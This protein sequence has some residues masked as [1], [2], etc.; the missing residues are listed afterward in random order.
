MKP[1]TILAS[2]AAFP[3]ER[4]FSMIELLVVLTVL[5][6][7][8]GAIVF[9]F[10]GNK[11]AYAADDEAIKILS[12]CR[13]AYQRALSQRQAQKLT[14]DRQNKLVKLT[15]MGTL[16]GGDEMLI[17]RGVLNADVSLDQPRVGASLLPP[18]PAPYNYAPAAFDS[19][20]TIDL[21]FLADG[22][23]TNSTGFNNS[24]FAPVSLTIFFSPSTGTA[25][26]SEQVAAANAGNLMRAITI[27]GPTGSAKFW[28]FDKDKFIWEIN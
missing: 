10:R 27:Y 13:E 14:I 19:A 22:S 26:T 1:K 18:P 12:F 3:R 5:T 17:N 16:P 7:M 28:R 9:A 24:T 6:I 8:T 2:S 15:D 23:V 20:N 25:V 21:V 4:G 11:R